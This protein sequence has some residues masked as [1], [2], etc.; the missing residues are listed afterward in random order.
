MTDL[1]DR[2]ISKAFSIYRSNPAGARIGRPDRLA[3]LFF[4]L[5]LYKRT[6]DAGIRERMMGELSLLEKDLAERRTNRYTLGRGS[7]GIAFFYLE[8]CKFTGDDVWLRK[9]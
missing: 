6:G 2:V 1:R 8:L 4:L 7:F 9:A 3:L 5:E